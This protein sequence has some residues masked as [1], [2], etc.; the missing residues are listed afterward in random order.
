MRLVVVIG[1]IVDAVVLYGD[2]TAGVCLTRSDIDAQGI[3]VWVQA[4][5]DGVFDKR[6]Q[7]KG[8]YAEA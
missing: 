4:V 8:R 2:L 3:A 1:L 7:G 5:L 6:L